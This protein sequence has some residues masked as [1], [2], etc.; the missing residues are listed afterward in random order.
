MLPTVPKMSFR[1][2]KKPRT[3][4][5]SRIQSRLIRLNLPASRRAWHFRCPS[6]ERA[7]GGEL[8]PSVQ[9]GQV[10]F[11]S[12]LQ[13]PSL[14]RIKGQRTDGHLAPLLHTLKVTHQWDQN[15]RSH[16][17][18]PLGLDTIHSTEKIEANFTEWLLGVRALHIV[19]LSAHLSPTA[20][21][22]I[23]FCRWRNS[24]SNLLKVFPMLKFR[25]KNE[26]G[27]KHTLSLAVRPISSRL[28]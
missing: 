28:N 25:K 23:P 21:T 20:S 27:R 22:V 12:G 19:H 6:M 2:R 7:L 5:W 3:N 13:P 24:L 17:Q 16:L 14:V 18:L 26:E 10:T 4:S 15:D 1:A 9:T 8:P 11:L